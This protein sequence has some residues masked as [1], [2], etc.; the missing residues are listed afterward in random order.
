[1]KSRN[2]GAACVSFVLL[3]FSL[4]PGCASVKFVQRNPATG[5]LWTVYQHPLGSDTITYCPATVG[6][7]CTEAQLVDAPSPGL[8]VTPSAPLQ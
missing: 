6:A 8:G 4:L 3:C 1:M 5:E 7:S 2:R